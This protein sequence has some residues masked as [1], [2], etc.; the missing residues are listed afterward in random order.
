MSPVGGDDLVML[1]VLGGLTFG[2]VCSSRTAWVTLPSQEPVDWLSGHPTRTGGLRLVARSCPG[3]SK[4]SSKK[5]QR[6]GRTER[7]WTDS[8]VD[9][10]ARHSTGA[11]W[12]DGGKGSHDP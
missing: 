9:G 10:T 6:T 3:P 4:M 2:R 11:H 12:L 5:F 7:H 1:S 8:G